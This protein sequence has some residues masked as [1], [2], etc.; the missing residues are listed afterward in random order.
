MPSSGRVVCSAYG[1]FIITVIKTKI[2]LL[3]VSFYSI[4]YYLLLLISNTVNMYIIIKIHAWAEPCV[5]ASYLHLC[6][7]MDFF[8]TLHINISLTNY[9]NVFIELDS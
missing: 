3:Q 4:I 1:V 8:L 2:Q 9:K 7:R 5:K 6:P